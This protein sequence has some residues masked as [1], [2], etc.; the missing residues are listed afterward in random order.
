MQVKIDYKA[1]QGAIGKLDTLAGAIDSERRAACQ[2]TPIALPTLSDGTLGRTAAWLRDQKPMLDGLHDIALLLADKGATVASFTVGNS[3]KDIKALL[4]T[5]LADKAHDVHFFPGQDESA[6]KAYLAVFQKWSH[7]P[8]TMA[9]FQGALGPEGS[10]RV[11]NQWAETPVGAQVTDTQR[12][13]VE[14]MKA[15][16]QAATGPGGFSDEE[17][18]A[19]AHGLVAEATRDPED[20]VGRGAYNPSGALAYLL[21]DGHFSDAF[22]GTALDDLDQY[23]RQDHGGA[24]KLWGGRPDNGVDFAQFM[25][26]G[27]GSPY[28]NLDPVASAMSAVAHNPSVAL[29]FFSN[30]DGK[31]PRAE[32]YIKERNWDQDCFDGISAALDAATTDPSLLHGSAQQQHD[33]A[34]LA[35]KTVEYFAQRK[36][37][38]DIP[39]MLARWPDNGAAEDLGHILSTYMAG[40]DRGLD[41]SDTVTP[42]VASSVWSDTFRAHLSNVPLF[43]QDS[44]KKFLL[45]GTAT[46]Q[47]LAE[48]TH[49]MNQ[50]RGQVLGALADGM[51][52]HVDKD[53]LRGAI[54]R[55]A[56][57]QGFLLNTLGDD[58]VH[59]AHVQD[60]RT[61]ATIDMLSDVVDVV[62][63]PG[64]SKLAEGVG[65]DAISMVIDHAKGA[66]FDSLEDHLAHAEKDTVTDMN[67]LAESTLHREQ[68]TVASLLYSHG[69]AKDADR[70]S[71]VTAPYGNVI[72]YDDYQKL[73]DGDK[74]LVESELFSTQLGVGH[75]F[76]PEDYRLQYLSEFNDPFHEEGSG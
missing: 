45:I 5:T 31:P 56:R 60:E 39:G 49:G 50:Y 17:A 19:F 57:L 65:K 27:D 14:A 72:S 6:A 62:P 53:A 69:L 16:L 54:E 29:G 38:D 73:S 74:E 64:M 34:V 51:D 18:R 47:G 25:P 36:Y 75:A 37:A 1:L 76:N 58:K 40:V 68:F 15:S 61:K 48:V 21:R 10:L 24:A 63:V 9:A 32:Y 66:G 8:A 13:F 7:D 55:D 3:V 26:W 44:L 23:E 46:D 22:I 71:D 28:D 12:A 35:S 42:G 43:D 67:N 20:L 52:G 11:L 4:G 2:G 30:D 59:D 33:A 41:N 70:M